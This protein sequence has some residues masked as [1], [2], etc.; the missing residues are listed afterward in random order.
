MDEEEKE[1]ERKRR[2]ELTIETREQL[3]KQDREWEEQRRKALGAEAIM[4]PRTSPLK[5][6]PC[7]EEAP[8][9]QASKRRKKTLERPVIGEQWGEQPLITLARKQPLTP[10]PLQTGSTPNRARELTGEQAAIH[11]PR[12]QSTITKFFTTVDKAPLRD[13]G[14]Q[15]QPEQADLRESMTAVECY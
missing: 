5:R 7:M 12:A 1:E 2:R 15:E 3:N 4:G 9:A 6:T 13:K 10:A 14:G 11:T 8:G